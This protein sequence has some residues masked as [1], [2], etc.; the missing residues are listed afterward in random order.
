MHYKE[1]PLKLKSPNHYT[2]KKKK[3]KFWMVLNLPEM[4]KNL[5]ESI[6]DGLRPSSILCR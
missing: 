6:P 4:Q 2:K 1:Q 5:L 3:S